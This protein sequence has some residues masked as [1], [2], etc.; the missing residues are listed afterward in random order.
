MHAHEEA[1]IRAFIDSRRQG[2]WLEALGSLK[3][4]RTFL[5]RL[6]H[7]P[8]ID[9]RFSTPLPS[10]C[11][12]FAALQ[13]R[14]APATCYIISDTAEIDGIELP[15]REALDQTE[16]AGWGTLISCVPGRLAFFYDEAG[17]R[18]RLVLERPAP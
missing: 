5:Q 18:R 17:T 14:G 2:R 3:R 8:D 12:V 16:F 6:N 11:D 7:C 15:L 4:R 13:N 10:N 9:P 1:T